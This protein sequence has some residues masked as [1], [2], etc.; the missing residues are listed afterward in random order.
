MLAVIHGAPAWVD[1]GYTSGEPPEEAGAR[2][3][4][5]AM[6]R[7]PESAAGAHFVA[8]ACLMFHKLLLPTLACP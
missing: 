6:V 3:I 4:E 1:Q 5:P 8:V 7:L 2:G